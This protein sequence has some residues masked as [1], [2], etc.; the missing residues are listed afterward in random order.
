MAVKKIEQVIKTDGGP[1]VVIRLAKV[2]DMRRIQM[3]YAEVYG[4]NYSISLITDKE[5][6]R[7]AIED[8]DYYWVVADCQGRIIG[9][10][11]YAV[12]LD[13]RISKAFG[14]VVSHDYRKMNL[15]YT[16]M[17][18]VLDD[19]THNKKLVDTVYATTR[20]ANY[21]PQKLT[22]SLGFIKTG[23]FPN[24]HKVSENETHCFAAYITE[25]ALKKRRGKPHLIPEVLPFYQLIRKQLNLDNPIISRVQG[26]FHELRNK[27]QLIPLETITAPGFIKNRYKRVKNEGFF[28]HIYMPFHEPNMIFITPDQSTEVYLQSN[29]DNYCVVIG[30]F[31]REPSAAVVLESVA[32]KLNEMRMS[33][34]EVILDAYSPQLQREAMDAR[35]IPSGYY[36][37]MKK[38]GGRQ[39]DCI[40]FSRT[41]EILDFRNVRI[42]SL[43]KNFL[44]EY[45]K[46]WRENYVESAFRND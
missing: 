24:T 39:H 45:L 36:P 37:C 20:T 5:K 10:L 7:R 38:A 2:P 9:S 25:Q 13:D 26:Q 43:Y 16:M 3:L 12:D 6:M 33:Y 44:R 34:I 28:A 42:L 14:A 15:A 21:A 29:K 31:T 32:Q 1:D 46:L 22:E 23:I 11:V 4:G 19:I 30:G 17:K 41:F 35:F 18:L 8:D 27:A 40:V